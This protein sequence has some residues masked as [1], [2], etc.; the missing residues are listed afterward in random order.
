VV[1]PWAS[2]CHTGR[3]AVAT[4]MVGGCPVAVTGS[5][6]QTVRIWD[7]TGGGLV[8]E[9]LVGH[10]GPVVTV[11]TGVVD[12]RPVAVTGSSDRTLRVWHLSSGRL[13]GEPLV[14]HTGP[15]NAVATVTIAGSRPLA[16]TGSRDRTVR[17]WDLT[18]GAAMG[19]PL[20]NVKV[21]EEGTPV[22]VILRGRFVCHVC[23]PLAVTALPG[24]FFGSAGRAA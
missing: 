3:V 21:G 5:E 9:P 7:L 6:D 20:P 4:G 11:A 14:G 2:P 8:G 1:A 13:V 19:E 18:T 17:I 16:V 24:S 15:I 10:T 23:H 12:G 22:K